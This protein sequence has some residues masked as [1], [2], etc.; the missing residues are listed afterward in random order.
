MVLYFAMP[1]LFLTAPLAE[2]NFSIAL[3]FLKETGSGIRR[4]IRT[5]GWCCLEAS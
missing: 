2:S 3:P 4:T 5:T 1:S